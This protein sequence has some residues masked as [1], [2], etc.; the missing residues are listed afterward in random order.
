MVMYIYGMTPEDVKCYNELSKKGFENYSLFGSNE[1]KWGFFFPLF[2]FIAGMS[3]PFFTEELYAMWFAL[4][5]F[6][7]YSFAVVSWAKNEK[8]RDSIVKSMAFIWFISLVLAIIR[9][10]VLNDMN[11]NFSTVTLMGVF[12]VPASFSCA[13]VFYLG[14]DIGFK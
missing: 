12:N 1:N 3:V 8:L 11:T 9:W 6:Y 13:L 4:V 5:P 10:F 2:L 14:K 7:V